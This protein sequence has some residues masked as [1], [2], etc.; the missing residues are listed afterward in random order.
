MLTP[1][2]PY[3]LGATPDSRGIN[4]ALAAPHA[5]RVELGLFD[6]TGHSEQQR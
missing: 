2:L 4:F 5:S 6:T 1:G 3:P